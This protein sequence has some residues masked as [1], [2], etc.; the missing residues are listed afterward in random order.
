MSGPLRRRAQPLE[1][2]TDERRQRDPVGLPRL[3]RQARSSAAAVEPARAAQR[4]D[5]DVHQCRHGAVQE[6]LHRG[7]EAALCARRHLAEMRARR[8]QAQR[9]RQCRLHGPA[10]HLLRDARQFL[11]RRLLQAA[12]HRACL[13]PDHQ[14]VRPRK[15][16]APG[17]R[18]SHGRRG[19][20]PLEE[21]RRPLRREDHPHP[22]LRQ[23]LADG[24]HRPVRPVFGDL[25]RPRRGLSRRTARQPG[26]GRRPLPRIL[27]PRLHAIR[28]DRAGQPGAAAE[29]FDRYR[30][31][32][33]AHGGG[34]ARRAQQLRH[35]PVPHADRGRGACD[36]RALRGRA[37]GLAPGHRRSPARRVVPRRRRRASLQRGPRLRAPPHHAPRHAPR[38]AARRARSGHVSARAG[39]RPRDGP[40]LS[41]ARARRAAHHRD[42]AAR[43]EPLPQD[44]RARPCHPGRGDAVAVERPKTVRRDRLH[45]LRHLWLPARPDA[46]RA[47]VA[48][49]RRRYGRLQGRHGAAAREG[50]RGLGRLRRGGDRDGLVRAARAGRRHRVPRL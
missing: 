46:G 4:S 17:H 33:R 47:Q 35:G 38:A 9:P 18:L 34:A 26:R 8:R 30:H 12:R 24:R 40:G 3:L 1:F 19:G 37:Q 27:E 31:G 28:A 13:D 48:R 22:D 32:A 14:G 7:R 43:G 23:F 10:P 50:A 5:P 29:A 44:A 45:A 2:C 25:H 41:R 39:A 6:R 49:H 11:V 36:R 20:R 15:G 16:Q 42:L 21:D